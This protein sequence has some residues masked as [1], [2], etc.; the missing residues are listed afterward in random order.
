VAVFGH[1]EGVVLD[2]GQERSDT[3]IVRLQNKWFWVIPLGPSKVSVGCVMDQEELAKPGLAPAQH[4]EALCRASPAMR[5]RMAN[6]RLMG[7][8]QTT[9]DFSYYNRKLASPRLLRIGDAAGFMDPIFS[10]GV[11]LAMFSGKLAANTVLASLAAGDDGG[12]RLGAYEKRVFHAMKLYWRMVEGFYTQS[13]FELFM[14]P[15][16]KLDLPDTITAILAGEVD[17][18]WQMSWRRHLFFA[19]ARIQKRYPLVPRITF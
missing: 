4:F 9:S 3:V 7:T 19:L 2:D 8:I 10:A 1:F 17:G 11:F 5:T 13:F 18:G 6:A 14:E 15:R 12:S 16:A